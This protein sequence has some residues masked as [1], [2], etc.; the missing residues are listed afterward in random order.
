MTA[1]NDL[2]RL[3]THLV[4]ALEAVGVDLEPAAVL[5]S[6]PGDSAGRL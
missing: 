6:L 1:D 5:E 4:A 2:A 3:L